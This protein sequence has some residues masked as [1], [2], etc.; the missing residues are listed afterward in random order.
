MVLLG[1][2]ALYGQGAQ[3]LHEEL[4]PVTARWI[5]PSRRDGPLC[6]YARDTE[7][8]TLA[9]LDESLG[10]DAEQPGEV[11]RQ[12]LLSAAPADVE[13]LRPKLEQRAKALAEDALARLAERGKAE[14]EQL[15]GGLRRQRERVIEELARHEGNRQ[16]ALDFNSDEAEQLEANKRHW[17]RRLDSF[18][19]DLAEEPK[20]IEA[21]YE[22]RAQRVEPV[23]LVYLWPET[24]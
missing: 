3:R 2:L 12:R 13:A 10:G 20:R 7:T 21:F 8:R 11:V 15:V 5:E 19:R 9:L 14:A 18:D 17:R 4:V 16:L 6:V 1:R 22:V 23:G 24:N